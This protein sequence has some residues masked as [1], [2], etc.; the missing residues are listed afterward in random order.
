MRCH[1]INPTESDSKTEKG[2]A[3]KPLATKGVHKPNSLAS[4]YSS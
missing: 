2:Q 3:G 4:K 1:D